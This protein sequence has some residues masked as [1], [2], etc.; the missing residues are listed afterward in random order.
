MTLWV[1]D[2]AELTWGYALQG[3]LGMDGKAPVGLKA[4]GG[5]TEVWRVTDLQRH[6]EL[7]HT[8]RIR[9]VGKARIFKR[10]N[11]QP[12]W[13]HYVEMVGVGGDGIVTVGHPQDVPLYVFFHHIPWSSAK[14]QSFALTDGVEPETAVQSQHTTRLSVDDLSRLLAQKFTNIIVVVYFPEETNSLA[15]FTMGSRETLAFG[16]GADLIFLQVP[17]GKTGLA[18]LPGLQLGEEVC[19]ILDRVWTG[20]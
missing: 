20:T 6:G 7:W 4:D 17:Y 9:W 11:G 3:T 12:M 8:S 14:T 18:K 13:F 1:V 5:R 2:N 16:N 19:L 15:V 10:V